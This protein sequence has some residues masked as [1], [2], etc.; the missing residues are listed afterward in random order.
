[1]LRPKLPRSRRSPADS[2]ADPEFSAAS[3]PAL[4][5][6][7]QTLP[8][9]K[10]LCALDRQIEMLAAQSIDAQAKPSWKPSP[11]S[12]PPPR[13]KSWPYL[14][15]EIF[16]AGSNRQAAARLQAFMGN[17]PRLQESGQW[18]GQTKMSK[19][20]VEIL[21]TA[22]FQAAFNASDMIPELRAFYRR[23]RAEGQSTRS[24]LKPS[25][26]HPHPETGRCPALPTTL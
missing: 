9:W 16:H 19:R 25:H 6:I 17:D 21:R 5:F 4:Q 15:S 1:M 8:R 26:A 14:P 10:P 23:K 20:G 24:R 2:L 22:F 7:L 18:K 13:L 11:A 12:D 3:A